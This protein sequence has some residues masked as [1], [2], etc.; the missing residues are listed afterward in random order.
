L[1]VANYTDIKA[2]AEVRCIMAI[3]AA[4]RIHL[5]E[6]AEHMQRKSAKA[7]HIQDLPDVAGMDLG[8]GMKAWAA[9]LS[10]DM[11]GSSNRAVRIG[12]RKTYVTM[13]TYLPVMAELASKKGYVVG[14]RGD[15]LFA[16]FGLTKL[17]GTNTEVD[18]EIASNAVKAASHTGK[19]MLEATEEA[20]SETLVKHNIEGNV[21]VRVGVDIGEIVVTRIGIDDTQEVTTYGPAVNKACKMGSPGSVVIS[22]RANNVWNRVKGGTLRMERTIGGDWR[23]NYGSMKMLRR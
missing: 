14:L 6:N 5:S 2:L 23:V 9:I 3:E 19:A 7:R 13:H 20:I 17:I 1:A 12:A 22:H 16:A 18:P 11:V 4:T 21:R 8:Y 10:V 15:G